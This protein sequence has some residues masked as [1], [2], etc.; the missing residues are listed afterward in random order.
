VHFD[1]QP[2]I[3]SA[4]NRYLCNHPKTA[5]GHSKIQTSNFETRFLINAEYDQ[6][7]FKIACRSF[8]NLH[9][10]LISLVSELCNEQAVGGIFQ[11]MKVVW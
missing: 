2:A 3:L 5:G 4:V 10:C 9:A 8:T 6:S 1:T 7:Q 11:N